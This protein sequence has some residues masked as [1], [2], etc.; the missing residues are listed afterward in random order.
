MNK[1]EN[2][3]ISFIKTIAKEVTDEIK[4]E[5]SDFETQADEIEQTEDIPAYVIGIG[6][7][8]IVMSLLL[9]FTICA[10]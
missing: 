9:I 1:Q 8:T 3:I 4:E 10:F 7:L 5:W 6:S 2:A